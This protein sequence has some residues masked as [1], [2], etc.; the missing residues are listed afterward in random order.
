L[1]FDGAIINTA[2]SKINRGISSIFIK[3]VKFINVFYIKIDFYMEKCNLK[4][5]FI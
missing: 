1:L 5:N 3:K 4:Y 2:M